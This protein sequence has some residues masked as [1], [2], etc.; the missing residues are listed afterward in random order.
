MLDTAKLGKW[1]PLNVI[2]KIDN[3]TMLIHKLYIV[4]T[5]ATVLGL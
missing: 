1:S 2:S 3:K 4:L 5:N